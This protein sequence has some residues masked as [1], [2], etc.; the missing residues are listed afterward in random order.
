MKKILILAAGLML[1]A[2]S[3]LA[4]N[5]SEPLY[6]KETAEAY[7]KTESGEWEVLPVQVYVLVGKKK[8]YDDLTFI[9][10]GREGRTVEAFV[11][12]K[13]LPGE[14]N[15][16]TR[17][18]REKMV[19][20]LKKSKILMIMAEEG[21]LKH[22]RSTGRFMNFDLD[23]LPRAAD[24]EPRLRIRIINIETR[25]RIT[26]YMDDE[27]IG[28]LVPLLEQAPEAMSAAKKAR[29]IKPAVKN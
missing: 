20:A 26:I 19:R 3:A 28:R 23:V 25:D 22:Q 18:E 5:K 24:G 16:A 7:H 14:P 6:L 13:G 29:K 9:K 4:A 12:E 17:D 2:S 1:L 21:D 11:M 15:I 8:Y 10:V 27:Q